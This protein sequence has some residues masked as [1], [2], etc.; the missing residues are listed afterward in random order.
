VSTGG[1]ADRQSPEQQCVV[2]KTPHCLTRAVLSS[3]VWCLSPPFP[4][5]SRKL[6]LRFL[7]GTLPALHPPSPSFQCSV[8]SY[9][10]HSIQHSNQLSVF[11]VVFQP[12]RDHRRRFNEVLSAA[13]DFVPVFHRGSARPPDCTYIRPHPESLS[14]NSMIH[15]SC[16]RVRAAHSPSL[17]WQFRSFDPCHPLLP[18]PALSNPPDAGT[19]RPTFAATAAAACMVFSV[20]RRTSR[21]VRH[22]LVVNFGAA[23]WLSTTVVSPPRGGP[24]PAVTFFALFPSLPSGCV[25]LAR[26]FPYPPNT[27]PDMHEPR[28]PP[29]SH[30]LACSFRQHHW[31]KPTPFSLPFPWAAPGGTGMRAPSETSTPFFSPCRP[32]SSWNFDF[33]L[34][35]LAAF[36]LNLGHFLHTSF[37]SSWCISCPV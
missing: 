12:K 24:V 5:V 21:R 1:P 6:Q 37:M 2:H 13:P 9:L 27:R 3:A 32:W 7:A 29:T 22:S 11:Q 30:S 15:P 17:P 35:G 4:Q 14:D 31:S 28:V 33:A 8:L 25:R 26:T 20:L 16:T 18:I 19:W 34:P 10:P 23:S 36:G